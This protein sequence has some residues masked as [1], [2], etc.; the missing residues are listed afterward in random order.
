VLVLLEVL[1][2]VAVLLVVVVR[3]QMQVV[4]VPLGTVEVGMLMKQDVPVML[5]QEVHHQV[6]LET[7]E[8]QVLMVLTQ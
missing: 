7:V 8:A 4:E 3:L 1:V 5:D 2:L 6:L